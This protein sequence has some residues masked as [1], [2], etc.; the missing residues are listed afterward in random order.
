MDKQYF[1]FLIMLFSI[2]IFADTIWI[3]H[4]SII[5]KMDIN[6]SEQNESN[7]SVDQ[8]LTAMFVWKCRD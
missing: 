6:K 3:G 7:N 2:Q 8:N 4:T 1:I 5:E